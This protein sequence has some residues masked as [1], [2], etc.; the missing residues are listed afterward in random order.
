MTSYRGVDGGGLTLEAYND[1]RH[2]EQ[3]PAP[4]TAE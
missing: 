4:V 2:L 3:S 1:V